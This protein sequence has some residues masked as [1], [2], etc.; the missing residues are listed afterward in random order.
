MNNHIQKEDV[1]TLPHKRVLALSGAREYLRPYSPPDTSNPAPNH[2]TNEHTAALEPPVLTEHTGKRRSSASRRSPRRLAVPTDLMTSPH[3]TKP[4]SPSMLRNVLASPRSS[5]SLQKHYLDGTPSPNRSEDGRIHH[6]DTSTNTVN[7]DAKSINAKP[8]PLQSRKVEVSSPIGS[9]SPTSSLS[10]LS[11]SPQPAIGVAMIHHTGK[12]PSKNIRRIDYGNSQSVGE[13]TFCDEHSGNADSDPTSYKLSIPL[14]PTSAPSPKR[15]SNIQQS[16]SPVA[17]KSG[18]T[19]INREFD[20]NYDIQSHRRPP[21]V[22]RSRASHQNISTISVRKVG[23]IERETRRESNDPPTKVREH[24]SD[25][26]LKRASP[27]S[28]S[29]L[30][31]DDASYRA[32]RYGLGP[33]LKLSNDA[34]EIILGTPKSSV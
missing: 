19:R 21:Y 34:R 2:P 18:S 5:S 27:V 7:T 16:G 1:A 26:K 8:T 6:W 28:D 33:T 17:K 15:Y 10:S 12:A 9:F 25:I 31:G 24:T 30:T 20:K 22:P 23:I 29:R 14:Q 32:A 11:D 4:R 3:T 13:D